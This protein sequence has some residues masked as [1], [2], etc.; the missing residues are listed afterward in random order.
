M[1]ASYG[2]V[3]DLPPR[4]GAVDPDA[5]FAMQWALIDR[6]APQAR[7]VVQKAGGSGDSTQIWKAPLTAT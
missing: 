4:A 1:L 3:R 5:D 6:A 2:H 7:T